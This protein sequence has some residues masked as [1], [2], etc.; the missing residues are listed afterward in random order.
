MFINKKK[1]N[2]DE[3]L[4]HVDI[5]PSTIVEVG[6]KDGNDTLIVSK[7]F[8]KSKYFAYEANPLMKKTI[9]SKLRFRKNV[10]FEN[11]GLGEVKGTKPFFVYAPNQNI[12]FNT[13]GASSFYNRPD[14]ENITKLEN[15]KI[16]TLS[17]EMIKKN[18]K[19]IDILLMDVQGYELN[20][21]KGAGEKIADIAYIIMETPKPKSEKIKNSV[22]HNLEIN[23]YIGAPT[24]SE[25]LNF[26]G[27]HNFSLIE[28]VDENLWET[29]SL[30]KNNNK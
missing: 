9:E 12:D 10:V 7:K 28:S 13:I 19:K 16:N 1:S 15:C 25:V 11:V 20:V 6:I 23:D 14:I 24:H 8:K 30:F 4:S 18:I 21:L 17:D 3:L 27:E 2:Y 29:N 26:M 22:T 5:K